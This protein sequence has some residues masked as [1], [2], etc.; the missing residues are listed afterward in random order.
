MV[1][2]L[3]AASLEWAFAS[4]VALKSILDPLPVD[5]VPPGSNVL[6]AA[7]LAVNIIGV[8]PDIDD[9]KSLALAFD[10]GIASIMAAL[11]AKLAIFT[12]DKEDPTTA[13]V[14]NSSSGESLLELVKASEAGV[15]LLLEILAHFMSSLVLSASHAKPVEVMV[16]KLASL[17]AQST[18]RS[19]LHDV[20]DRLVL[21]ISRSA[22]KFSELGS[23]ALVMLLVMELDSLS[24]DVGLKSILSIRK[25]NDVVGG[26]VGISINREQ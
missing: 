2:H 6:R 3:L 15:D 11:N 24:R 5:K 16:E 1:H 14:T 7:V 19:V 21:E 10:S 9:K 25:F 8:L 20:A 4:L 23:V 13:K 26:H 17:V 12:K 22:S 18:S